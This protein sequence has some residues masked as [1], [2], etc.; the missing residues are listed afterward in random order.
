MCREF[1]NVLQQYIAA[2]AASMC[3]SDAW[4]LPRGAALGACLLMDMHVRAY[5]RWAAEH[6][7]YGSSF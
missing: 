7:F 2:L 3:N 6:S 5:I 4:P 1:N